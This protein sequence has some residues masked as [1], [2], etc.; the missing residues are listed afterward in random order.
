MAVTAGFNH[1]LGLKADG[2]LYSWGSNSN[3]QLG[4][5]PGG[6]GGGDS[7]PHPTPSEVA[8]PTDW[9]AV[10]AGYYHSLGL[11]ADGSLWAWGGNDYGQ[12]G[13]EVPSIGPARRR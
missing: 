1:S 13:L 5:L 9:V 2:A 4:L 6:I 8:A 10:T 7:N 12:L 3:G 11:K